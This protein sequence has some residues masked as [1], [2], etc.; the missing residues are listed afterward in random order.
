MLGLKIFVRVQTFRRGP[1]VLPCN[2]CHPVTKNV[3]FNGGES[4]LKCID[5]S[6]SVFFFIII[7]VIIITFNGGNPPVTNPHHYHY[8]QNPT[9]VGFWLV[10]I[11]RL[12]KVIMCLQWKKNWQTSKTNNI[13]QSDTVTP[14]K[15]ATAPKKCILMGAAWHQLAAAGGEDYL[16]ARVNYAPRLFWRWRSKSHLSHSHWGLLGSP[17]LFLLH[18]M[19]A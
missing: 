12:A 6:C 3:I 5:I 10:G 16:V 11:C 9:M 4:T 7:I 14:L 8:C 15:K 13:P 2:F 18:R 17:V 19:N 1:P